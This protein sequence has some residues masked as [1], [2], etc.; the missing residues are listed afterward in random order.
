MP[1]TIPALDEPLPLLATIND[2]I[3]GTLPV[4]DLSQF[5]E[6][7]MLADQWRDEFMTG[8]HYWQWRKRG[9]DGKK[10]RARY[11]GKAE[12]LS[13]E[14]RTAYRARSAKL[15]ETKSRRSTTNAD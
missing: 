14:R 15:A 6:A 2:D 3:F 12:L 5:E 1:V 9:K 4:V 13:D 11:G 8:G 7:P 10:E